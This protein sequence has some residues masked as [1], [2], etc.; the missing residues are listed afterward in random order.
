MKKQVFTSALALAF[1]FN[2]NSQGFLQ[3][4]KGET[5]KKT[6]TK[7]AEEKKPE[8]PLAVPPKT[9]YSDAFGISG[10]YYLSKELLSEANALDERGYSSIKDNRCF[11]QVSLQLDTAKKQ[12][13]I[14]YHE[15]K[16]PV[17]AFVDGLVLKGLKRGAANYDYTPFLIDNTSMV[18][19]GKG[20]NHN[21]NGRTMLP[22]EKDMYIVTFSNGGYGVD[23]K[24]DC[25]SAKFFSEEGKNKKDYVLLGK[26][27]ARVEE[28]NANPA[29]VETL[30][31]AA[32]KEEC[33]LYNRCRASTNTLPAEGMKDVK[34]KAEALAFAKAEQAKATRNE[35]VEYS[36]IASKDWNYTRNVTTG[37]I[38]KRSVRSITIVKIGDKCA[39]ENGVIT[40]NYD[41]ANYGPSVWGGNGAPV[42]TDCKEAYKY[43]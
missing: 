9:E 27:K 42:I 17:K 33:E 3:K 6:E 40:Q 29:L 25:S 20:S 8:K 11:T 36:Y 26:S 14:H 37:I 35:K 4:I 23:V 34:L 19:E 30:Y 32:C 2:V 43:K 10:V 7:P 39:Y 1:C 16:E 31:L 5:N 22:L 12:L 18:S 28:L 41:G 13:L 21:W 15:G 24:L 38:I